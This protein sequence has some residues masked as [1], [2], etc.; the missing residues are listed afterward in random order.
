MINSLSYCITVLKIQESFTN[1]DF[2]VNPWKFLSRIL[3]LVIH[4]SLCSQNSWT[5]VIWKTFYNL[6][7]F[8]V[9]I[10]R[11][12]TFSSLTCIFIWNF[13]FSPVFFT[14]F[15]SKNQLPGFF[16]SGTLGETELNIGGLYKFMHAK[17]SFLIIHMFRKCWYVLEMQKG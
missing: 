6:C 12:L 4:K 5:R 16:I 11:F 7:E 13:L 9:L 14:Y 17:F 2:G 3:F 8:E 1:R 10:Y 15:A